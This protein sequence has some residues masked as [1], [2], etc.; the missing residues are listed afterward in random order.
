[1]AKAVSKWDDIG[2]LMT[3]SQRK[4]IEEFRKAARQFTKKATRSR[5]AALKTLIDAGF[6]TPKGNPRKPYR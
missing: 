3:A 4:E 5:K 1:M 6:F 2:G